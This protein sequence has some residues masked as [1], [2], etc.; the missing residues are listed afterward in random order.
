[1]Q[2][3]RGG[4]ESQVDKD[5]KAKVDAMSDAELLQYVPSEYKE[6]LQDI[7]LGGPQSLDMDILKTGA[8]SKK[9]STN[10][11]SELDVDELLQKCLN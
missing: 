8:A 11:V 4:A 6:S 7:G 5:L 3:P 2:S 9:A 10:Q 1:M